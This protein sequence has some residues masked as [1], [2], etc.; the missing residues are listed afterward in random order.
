MKTALSIR[1]LV[2][3][4]LL[5]EGVAIAWGQ[6]IVERCYQ[7]QMPLPVVRLLVVGDALLLLMALLGIGWLRRRQEMRIRESE[8]EANH[9]NQTNA[10][11]ET[12]EETNR[13]LV[14]EISEH[15]RV[16]V[17]LERREEL[18]G[19]VA[20]TLSI[21]ASFR[22]RDLTIQE[23][24]ALLGKATKA[25]RTAYFEA[26]DDP[27]SSHAALAW[28]WK[29][30]DSFYLPVEGDDFVIHWA[31][32]FL[33]WHA[34]LSCGIPVS[35]SMDKFAPRER[36]YF[37][38][39]NLGAFLALPVRGR[40]HFWGFLAFEDSDASREWGDFEITALSSVATSLGEVMD[41]EQVGE[42]L[43]KAKEQAENAEQRART[44]ARAAEEANRAK[45]DFLATMSHEIRTPMNAVIGMSSLLAETSIDDEQRDL[46][47]TIRSSGEA[48]LDLINDI[49]DFSKIEA[50]RIELETIAF[51]LR[52]MMEETLDLVAEK[53]HA[54]GLQVALLW[55]PALP[56][57]V[58]G[59]PSRIRQV[60]LNL[61]S[62]AVKFTQKGEIC[63]QVRCEID[64]LEN[65]PRTVRFR[66]SV[67]DTGIGLTSGQMARLFQPFTQADSSTTRLFGGTGLGLSISK[68]LVE[69]MG[70]MI[71]AESTPGQGAEFWFKLDLQA[72]PAELRVPETT[73]LQG[74]RALVMETHDL[75][76]R[77]LVQMLEACGMEVVFAA[78]AMEAGIA[79]AH[80][81]AAA[82]FDVAILELPEDAQEMMQTLQLAVGDAPPRLLAVSAIGRKGD[83][84]RARTAGFQ[85][86]LAKPVKMQL[87]RAALASLLGASETGNSGE[88]V[89]RHT[90]AEQEAR[91][92]WRILVVEDNPV[93][94]KVV[95]RMLSKLGYRCD[96]VANG[97]DAVVACQRGE[98]YHLVL[99]DC[100]MPEMDGWEATR[101]IREMEAQRHAQ[102]TVIL[103]LTADAMEGSSLACLEA[104]MD[105]FLTK[106]ISSSQLAQELERRLVPMASSL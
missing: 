99:M 103:A 37:R 36:E 46:V 75:E 93:N 90:L 27:Q 38:K 23:I 83:A 84:A 28:S 10:I 17:A 66:T 71:G 42:G 57:R 20:R 14:S 51:D 64:S 11:E 60:L 100:Q 77:M 12:L 31:P 91:A 6:W 49:L 73:P 39:W 56:E 33:R 80:A 1:S 63:L 53:A 34:L 13:R 55:D 81:A 98:P 58:V 79:L 92:R 4:V 86:Y 97:L 106:P 65:V 95:V 88:L 25:S 50:G 24:L 101:R 78:D 69:R 102:R 72:V 82:P 9:R 5:I 21:V 89:T 26:V 59:D 18:L 19:A 47:E 67:Q 61:L 32:D 8:L 22:H 96:V 35:G 87:L 30:E 68:K 105:G 70:G 48:L 29:S 85:A 54:K 76:R 7:R 40:E 94:Q 15:E 3:V 43:V 52:T 41:R 74:R 44:L 2:S 104:G 62:N 45:S 16:Q